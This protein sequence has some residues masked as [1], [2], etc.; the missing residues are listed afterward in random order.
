[1]CL[2]GFVEITRREDSY[3][4]CL[5]VWRFVLWDYINPWYQLALWTGWIATILQDVNSEPFHIVIV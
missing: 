3:Y 2:V 4:Q 5:V 1:M